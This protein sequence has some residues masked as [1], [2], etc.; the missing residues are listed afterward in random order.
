MMEIM[1]PAIGMLANVRNRRGVISS[2]E[3]FDAHEGR[4]HLVTVEYTDGDGASEDQ[5]IWEREPGAFLVPP[6]F[7]PQISSHDPMPHDDFDALV[8]AT[9]WTAISPFLDP[10]GGE[11]PLKRFP[12]AA[13]L[14]GAIQLEE[15]QLIPL[16]KALRMPRVSLLIADDVGLGKTI[17]AGLILSE[18]IIRRRVRRVMILCPAS[19]RGQWQTEMHEKFCLSFD[20][21]DREATHELRKRVGL[22]ANP[23]RTFQRIVASYYYLRQADVLSDFLAASRT[24]EGSPHLPWDLLIVDEA[25]NLSPASFGEDSDLCRMLNVISPYFEH[26]VFLTA[27][28][29]NGHTRSFTGLLE[30]LDPVRFTRSNTLAG[31]SRARVEDVLI[32]RLKSE[33][34]AVTNPP[35]FCERESQAIR[36]K[37]SAEE[38]RL[39]EAF[40]GFR[41]KV[42]S[43]IASSRRTE[44][45]AGSFAVEILGKRLLS[46]PVTFADSWHR[47]L[48]GA[49]EEDE[50][51]AEEVGAA[52]RAVRDETEDDLEFEGRVA[53]AARTVGAWLRPFRS[54]LA[55]ETSR[56]NAALGDLTLDDQN[57][58]AFQRL[59][60]KDSRFDALVEKIESLLRTNAKWRDDERLIVFTEYKTT[61]DYLEHRLK[62]CYRDDG[63]IRVLFGSQKMGRDDRDAVTTAFNNPR[64]P[65]RVLI[66]TDAASEGL[67]L[68]ETARY[69]L[70]FDVPWNPSRIEQRNG[71]LDRHGQARDVTAFHFESDDDADL[72]FLSYVVRKV[73]T[74]RE[75]LGSVGDVFD[76]ALQRRF[77]LGD[78]VEVIQA[79]VDKTVEAVRGR[80]EIPRDKTGIGE[81]KQLDDLRA[82]L[83]L[84]AATL[85]DTLEAALSI[86]F[87]RPRL[88]PPDDRG[89]LMLTQPIPPGWLDL[90][91]DT[92]R[93]GA[94]DQ[95]GALLGLVFDPN[96]FIHDIN[97]RPIFRPE[98]DTAFLHLAHPV[99]HRVLA[100][101][102]RLRFPGSEKIQKATR[103][104]VRRGPLPKSTDALVL[105]TVEELAVNELRESFHHWVRTV[106][107]P[108]V[109]D[110]LEKPLPHVPASRLTVLD[111]SPSQANVEAARHLWDEVDADA[112]TLLASMAETLTAEL[113]KALEKE[114]QSARKDAQERFTSR[115]REITALMGEQSLA[116]LEREIE[117]IAIDLRQG[118][119]FDPEG[120]VERLQ[121]TIAEKEEELER[122]QTHFAE[123]REQLAKERERVVDRLL[124]ARYTLRGSAQCFPVA[125]EIR[126]PE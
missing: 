108:I 116:K 102:A 35:R 88:S 41:K 60:S 112:K 20:D 119:L 22:D 6:S 77:F 30:M 79:D 50:V 10:D 93:R 32:R 98:R 29:H 84:N 68:Q 100:S 61:L 85:R 9:R 118:R 72:K 55:E 38:K 117:E 83:D 18:L 31:A 80:A 8:R 74:I 34:N 107:L 25:H 92:L 16:L 28:P 44:Q 99:Y 94:G 75:D 115:N 76:S 17:E 103:W 125:V 71:R 26:K 65:V 33:I 45:L 64:D 39:S 62:E 27:T 106:Q 114:A 14:Y 97:G 123:L 89:R 40:D 120:R 96:H 5:L 4:L 73:D 95:K 105:L 52:Q 21:V 11:G 48:K 110:Q 23:W 104:T 43:I 126:L 122:R 7:L 86:Q 56:I 51:E 37:L 91:D 12:I 87:G 67:N 58:S 53:H 24:P 111:G 59:P 42:R 66:A 109:K 124:P 121:R 15:F 3:P 57:G 13:P 90:I 63:V 78:S 69:L 49:A 70:H 36:L 101:F 47:Y 46:D 82:E 19:L 81:G 2:I 113:T 54:S 1:N